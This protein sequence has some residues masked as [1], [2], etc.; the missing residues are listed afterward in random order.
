MILKSETRRKNYCN[1]NRFKWLYTDVVFQ[2]LPLCDLLVKR[3]D[4]SYKKCYDFP[5][6]QKRG[7][8]YLLITKGKR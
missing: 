3:L 1:V 4:Q 5:D 8:V 2:P 7:S 6:P